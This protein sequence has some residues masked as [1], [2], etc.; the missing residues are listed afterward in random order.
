MAQRKWLYRKTQ[1]SLLT[2]SFWDK[3]NEIMYKIIN[4]IFCFIEKFH[5]YDKFSLQSCEYVILDSVLC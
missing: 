2:S 5:F 1:E 4:T 3:K